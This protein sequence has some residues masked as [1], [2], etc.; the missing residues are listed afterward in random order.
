MKFRQLYAPKT[1]SELVFADTTMK[2]VI[3]DYVEGIR[4]HHLLLYGP[5]GSGKTQA[6]DIILQ[7]QL[8]QLY[9]TKLSK[10]FNGQVM[11]IN[12]VVALREMYDWQVSNCGK[13]VLLVDEIDLASTNVRNALR[14]L[15]DDT[16]Y[17]TLICTTNHL[18][19]LDVP[20]QNRFDKREILLPSLQ[21]WLPRAQQIMREEGFEL[22][23]VELK[24]AL[25]GFNGSARDLLNEL[26]NFLLT[27]KRT[28]GFGRFQPLLTIPLQNRVK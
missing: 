26:E 1:L 22:T 24:Q 7:T 16:A 12:D 11:A 28:R 10:S 19:K 6:A 3:S 18:H 20:F 21:Q 17:A 14:D 13:A 25:Y 27:L 8:R 2:Q 23:T 5:A 4:N 15:I 9:G